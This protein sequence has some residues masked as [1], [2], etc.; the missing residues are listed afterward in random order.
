MVVTFKV[1]AVAAPKFGVVNEGLVANTNAPDPVS[2]VTALAKFALEGVP[3]NVATPAPKPLTPVE[4]GRPVQLVKVPELGVPNTGV[5][6]LAFVID[7]PEENT[8]EPLP[9]SSVKAAAKFA[10]EG[11]ASH[12]PTLA[13]NPDKPLETGKPVQLVNVPLLGV[14]NTG[15]VK[16]ALVI[17]GAEEKT[18]EP[19]PVSSVIAAAKFALDGVANHVAMLAPKPLIPVVTGKP[20]QFV[21]VPETG[22]PSAGDVKTPEF[23]LGVVKVALVVPT[24]WPVP[25]APFN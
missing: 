21:N 4:I 23:I 1:L 25:D 10:L 18:N 14:P 9:V 15:V 3:K 5:V 17:D 11:V 8:T 7:G 22:V 13:P 6:K 19:L 16:L 12:V 24:I 20:V 2:S